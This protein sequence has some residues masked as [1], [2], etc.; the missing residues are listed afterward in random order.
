[1]QI[2]H[3]LVDVSQSWISR[4]AIYQ[5][6]HCFIVL[7]TSK[8][9]TQ[10][11]SLLKCDRTAVLPLILKPRSKRKS[12]EYGLWMNLAMSAASHCPCHSLSKIDLATFWK[13]TGGSGLFKKLPF[14]AAWSTRTSIKL[15][16][17]S[18]KWD[19]IHISSTQFHSTICRCTSAYYIHSWVQCDTFLDNRSLTELKRLVKIKQCHKRS[20]K[21]YSKNTNYTQYLIRQ[22]HPLRSDANPVHLFHNEP[23]V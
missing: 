5:V 4:S 11:L 22:N 9:H 20:S 7:Q 17:S 23:S 1:V 21:L 16:S 13:S 14:N 19:G 2:V 8:T 12:R 3:G 18:L 6:I 15:I 10:I